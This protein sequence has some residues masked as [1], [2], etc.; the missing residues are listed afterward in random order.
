MLE[1]V[2]FLSQ[3]VS[4]IIIYTNSTTLQTILKK[5]LKERFKIGRN[6]TKYASTGAELKEIKNETFTPPFGG[7]TWF[8]DIQADKISI[9]DLGKQLN[10]ISSAAKSV[11]WFTNYSQFKKVCDLDVVKKQGIFCFIMYAG[12]L[13]PEDITYIHNIMVPAEKKLPKNLLDY[14]KK[15]YTYDVDAVCKVFQ[16][17]VQGME[18]KTTKDIINEVGIGGNTIDS[19]VIKLLTSNPKTDKGVKSSMEKMVVLLNDLSYS[20]EYKS[21]KNFMRVTLKSIV[22]IKQLQMM[23]M[24]TESIKNIPENVFNEDKIQRLKRYDKVI[25]N[26]INLGRVLNLLT[27]LEKHTDFN[28]EIALIK[29]ISDYLVWIGKKN[30]D[31]PESKEIPAKFKWR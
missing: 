12:K 10:L 2:E 23:G 13:Y 27:C 6:L 22:E 11:Y 29:S 14:L 9:S 17:I 28:A 1:K 7:G 25:L 30:Q 8:L 20:Y 15:N 18:F 4:N 24:Y 31:N 5:K 21:I 19:F 16:G 3:D 26:E